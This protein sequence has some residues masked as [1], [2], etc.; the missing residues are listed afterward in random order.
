MKA[1]GGRQVGDFLIIDMGGIPQTFRID[2]YRWKNLK[3]R[4]L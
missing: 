2:V 3:S 4:T 1:G